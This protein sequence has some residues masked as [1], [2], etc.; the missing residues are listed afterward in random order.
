MQHIPIPSSHHHDHI[1]VPY[2]SGITYNGGDWTEYPRRQGWEPEGF[3]HGDFEQRDGASHLAQIGSLLQAWL[4]FGFMNE[5]TGIDIDTQAF[6]KTQD[7]RTVVTTEG[8]PALV[9]QWQDRMHVMS[10]AEARK[11]A[12]RIDE[13][14]KSSHSYFLECVSD[15]KTHSSP[16]PLA[17]EICLSVSILYSTLCLAKAHIFKSSSF[18]PPTLEIDAIKDRLLANGWCE[19]DVEALSADK[20]GNSTI[21]IYYCSLLGPR[22]NRKQHPRCVPLRCFAFD[23]REEDYQVKHRSN[24]RGC[25]FVETD[26]SKLQ[27][28]YLDPNGG[29]D[30]PIPLLR[31]LQGKSAIHVDVT[32]SSSIPSYV[33]ISHVFGDGLGNPYRCALPSCQLLQLQEWVDKATSGRGT[34]FWID[35]MC[36]PQQPQY[37]DV[38][39]MGLLRMIKTYKSATMVL[40][41]N[42][43]LEDTSVTAPPEELAVRISTNSWFRRLWTLQ[44]GYLAG[45]LLFQFRDGMVDAR[46]V[47]QRSTA[48]QHRFSLEHR[49]MTTA[50]LSLRRLN[51]FRT[52]DVD[53]RLRKM[54]SLTPWRSTSHPEDE[55]IVLST[56]LGAGSSAAVNLMTSS[57]ATRLTKWKEWIISLGRLPVDV[58]FFLDARI[59]LDNFSWCPPNFTSRLYTS[60]VDMSSPLCPVDEEG[61]HL[62]S[63]AIV[64]FPPDESTAPVTQDTRFGFSA[65]IWEQNNSTIFRIENGF[66]CTQSNGPSSWADAMSR[67][68][69]SMFAV[70]PKSWPLAQEERRPLPPTT[71]MSDLLSTIALS[72]D[73]LMLISSSLPE[74]AKVPTAPFHSFENFVH[75]VDGS[76][77]RTALRDVPCEAA[78]VGLLGVAE[79]REIRVRY[80]GIVHLQKVPVQEFVDSSNVAL[81]V[82]KDESQEWCVM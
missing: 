16:L 4:Y 78:L 57:S 46:D 55:T 27:S 18:I 41:L 70:I 64:F 61:L 80:C 38:K 2:L 40:V 79:A 58:L 45:K 10:A 81:G 6:L 39:K 65:T 75:D 15:R 25:A 51:E 77:R 72:D 8:L 56:L 26:M 21:E 34:A 54:F 12:F 20:D 37:V 73:E 9:N 44:E 53:D 22:L 17:P 68:G 52:L 13:Y 74:G 76:Q 49:L 62:T 24:C 67:V 3:L 19:S 28:V 30:G 31:V 35:S 43:E 47:L 32:T 69:A 66:W 82:L 60:P 59:S 50:L 23:T 63:A 42:K 48:T 36:V 1:A 7:G 14:L 71:G 33:A 11:E 29:D 5:M